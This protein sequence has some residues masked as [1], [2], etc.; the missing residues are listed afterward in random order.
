MSE[1]VSFEE[2][3]LRRMFQDA[4]IKKKIED[5]PIKPILAR[6]AALLETPSR[7]AADHKRI[8]PS[9]RKKPP[10]TKPSS[11][12][13][14]STSDPFLPLRSQSTQ[15]SRSPT[16]PDLA[17]PPTSTPITPQNKRNIPVVRPQPTPS[18]QWRPHPLD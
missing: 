17:H 12:E 4:D 3:N 7:L 9:P 1:N 5:S 2:M 15:L 6:L 16:T 13:V 18:I 8:E 14:H 10:L 11:D